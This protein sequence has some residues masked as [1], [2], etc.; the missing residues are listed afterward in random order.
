MKIEAVRKCPESLRR[1]VDAANHLPVNADEILQKIIKLSEDV[2]NT[3]YEKI[4]TDTE[5]YRAEIHNL[6]LEK[7]VLDYLIG[8][9]PVAIIYSR[10]AVNFNEL[11]LAKPILQGIA[12]IN[13]ES[14]KKRGKKAFAET[15]NNELVRTL[16]FGKKMLGIRFIGTLNL[17]GGY[18]RPDLS[19][20]P[21]IFELEDI[22]P[23]RIRKCPICQ[24]IF[25]AKRI[26]SPTCSERCLNTFNGRNTRI[27]KL[28]NEI[29]KLQANSNLSSAAIRL[30]EEKTSKLQGKINQRKK[31]YGTL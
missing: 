3:A 22:P 8:E 13:R 6:K 2:I 30:K 16:I 11:I 23:E 24:N 14:I 28:E 25:W 21:L 7:E 17:V 12:E 5:S 20:L 10:V 9:M 31:K 18:I 15:Q 26:D 27:R 1:I 19:G 4:C 29:K